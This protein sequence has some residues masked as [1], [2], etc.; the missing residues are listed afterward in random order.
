M[1]LALSSHRFLKYEYNSAWNFSTLFADL[2]ESPNRLLRPGC[3]S[4][5]LTSQ[6]TRERLK[7]NSSPEST[8]PT[9]RLSSSGAMPIVRST[10]ILPRT[11]DDPYSNYDKALYLLKNNPPEQRL[12]IRLPYSQYLKLEERWSK[13]KSENS[14]PEEMRYPSLSYNSLM[15]IA[16][17]VTIQSALHGYTAAVIRDMIASA[18]NEYLSTHKPNEIRRIINSG[19]TTNKRLCPDGKS[20]KKP[21]ESFAYDHG[22]GRPRLQVVIECGVSENYRALCDDKDLWLQRLGAKV[23]VLI[24]LKETPQFKNP[25][26]A[27]QNIDDVIAEV[28][29][30]DQHVD[31]NMKHNLEQGNYGPIEYRNHM[32]FGRLNELFLEVWRADGKQPVRKWLIKDAHSYNPLPRTVG[33]KISDFFP[34]NEWSVFK[35]PDSNIHF[36]PTVL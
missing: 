23:V 25:R 30:M 24:C 20:S 6:T 2:L 12:D 16:T 13:F 7:V 9:T 18:V 29:R 14:I 1:M 27:Y 15:Q 33:V 34:D 10:D 28:E 11:D 22:H 3:L 36:R 26:T 31:G 21:D 5:S 4:P 35:I 19:S 8:R 32:W 17:V